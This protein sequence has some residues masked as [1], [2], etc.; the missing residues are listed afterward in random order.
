MLLLN[1]LGV[2]PPLGVVL[3]CWLDVCGAYLS[4]CVCQLLLAPLLDVVVKC[5][6]HAY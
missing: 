2:G 4:P 1:R 6:A 3:C 5:M